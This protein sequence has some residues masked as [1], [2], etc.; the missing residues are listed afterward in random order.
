MIYKLFWVFLG[1][2]LGSIVRYLM[3]DILKN[4]STDFPWGTF[5][6][7]VISCIVLGALVGLTMKSEL[8]MNQRLLF[9]T[10]FCGGFSTFSTFSAETFNLLQTGRWNI[11]VIY[12]LTSLIL[13]VLAIL[14]G[15]RIV[16]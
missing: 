1:G 11:A 6:A 10:G 14:L 8:S 4:Y 9:M 12:V 13:G 5:V 7:N 15:I 16:Q 3:G 2:G